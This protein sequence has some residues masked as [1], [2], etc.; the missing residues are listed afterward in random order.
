VRA[1]EAHDSKT[2]EETMRQLVAG[3]QEAIREILKARSR[4]E[5]A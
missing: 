1:I 3:S 2:A 5:A 4:R